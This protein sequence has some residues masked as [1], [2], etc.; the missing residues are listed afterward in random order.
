MKLKALAL[1]ALMALF[2][3]P[4]FAQTV[5]NPRVLDFDPSPDHARTLGD[6]PTLQPVVTGYRMKIA[7]PTNLMTFVATRDLGKPSP[8]LDGK[9]SITLPEAFEALPKNVAYVTVV[10]A[11]GPIDGPAELRTSAP[12]NPF[13]EAGPPLPPGKPALRR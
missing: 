7:L 4:A 9:I 13:V 3:A 2:G 11:Y 1:A 6:D 10:E 5:V 12:S 8:G